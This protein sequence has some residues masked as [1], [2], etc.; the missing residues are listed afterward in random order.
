MV[1]IAQ[2]V[3]PIAEFGKTLAG[4]L[5]QGTDGL[6]HVTLPVDGRSAGLP[7]L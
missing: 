2:R 1:G 3:M 4:Q 7:F 5:R 6:R